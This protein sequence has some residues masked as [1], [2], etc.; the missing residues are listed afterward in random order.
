MSFR[1]F[2]CE[3][4]RFRMARRQ[5]GFEGSFVPMGLDHFS[6]IPPVNWRAIVESPDGSLNAILCPAGNAESRQAIHC[7]YPTQ[8]DQGPSG[9]LKTGGVSQIRLILKVFTPNPNFRFGEKAQK[10][11]FRLRV[12]LNDVRPP[13]C[14]RISSNTGSAPS[15]LV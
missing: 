3:G 8:T 13:A 7:L 15:S 14:S 12:F 2:D 4:D 9:R 11:N 1:D 10:L 6:S 5:G